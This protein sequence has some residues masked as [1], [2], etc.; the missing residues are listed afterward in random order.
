M[1]TIRPFQAVYYNSKKVG[2][3][4]S[5]VC[6]PYD[7]I[8][9]DDQIA[10]LNSSPYN[11]THV[12]FNLDLPEDTPEK[13][14][15]TR[16]KKIFK[17]WISQG[18]MVQ[19]EV[20]AIYFYKQDYKIMGQKSSR[21]GFI[22]LMELEDDDESRVRPH[23]KTHANAVDDR[24]KLTTALNANLSSIFVCYS[25]KNR[26]VEKIFLKNI[27]A[28]KAFLDVE[29]KDHV[30]HKVWRLTDPALIE[31]IN[32]SLTGQQLFIA[33]GHH[34]YKVACDYRQWRMSQKPCSGGGEPFQ[35]VM[36]YFTNMDSKD[37]QIFPMHRVIKTSDFSLDFIEE[38]F[39]VDKIK[40]KQDLLIL[41]AKAGRNEH[42]F[43]LYTPEGIFLLRLKNKLLIHTKIHEGSEHYKNLDATILKAF[44]LD[45]IGVE[46][47]DLAYVKDMAVAT[48]MVDSG[49]AKA[50]FIMNPV[51]IEQ[52]RAVAM[53]GEKMPPKS[54]YFYPKV[55]SG[56]TVY[57]MD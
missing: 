25:D 18:V 51:R 44:I 48:D 47:V 21:L 3:L 34:R 46:S 1:S 41:L 14:K 7:V 12:D 22:S 16:A 5:V 10:L 28:E 19:D 11:F 54:T 13:N 35:Y 40:N 29:D 52:L 2:D 20:P 8:S 24:L 4:K 38:F 39:R 31:E 6:P 36:T 23:E 45:A 9:P 30:R 43:G 50:A 49:E 27:F 33:D 37:L 57:K 32:A 17:E 55:L 56:L 26:K 53:A 42:A 15:Y